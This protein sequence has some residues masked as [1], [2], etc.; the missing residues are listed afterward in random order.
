MI[1]F[2]LEIIIAA[3]RVRAHARSLARPRGGNRHRLPLSSRLLPSS[4]T[5]AALYERS[6]IIAFT[7]LLFVSLY[8]AGYY[9]SPFGVPISPDESSPR[10]L[11]DCRDYFEFHHKDVRYEI[12]IARKN[13]PGNYACTYRYTLRDRRAFTNIPKVMFAYLTLLHI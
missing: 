8:R 5:T 1:I 3:M 11:L 10:L 13:V 6:G 12:F 9:F 4:S 7:A 2:L